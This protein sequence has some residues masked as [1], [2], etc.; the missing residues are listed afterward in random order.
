MMPKHHHVIMDAYTFHAHAAQNDGRTC[1]RDIL[2]HVRARQ[3]ARGRYCGGPEGMLNEARE[4][5]KD[6]RRGP[7]PNGAVTPRQ[8]TQAD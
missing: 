7:L 1:E 4:Q 2:Q 5:M 6:R 8:V 3:G